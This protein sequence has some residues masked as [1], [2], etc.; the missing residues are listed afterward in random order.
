[1]IYLIYIQLRY[2]I[3][4]LLLKKIQIHTKQQA[5]IYGS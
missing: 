4:G 1:M 3:E 5:L 2:Y